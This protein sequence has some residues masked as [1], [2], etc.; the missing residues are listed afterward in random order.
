MFSKKKRWGWATLK[1]LILAQIL[2][3]CARFF[4]NAAIK[5]SRDA[6][7]KSPKMTKASLK[8]AKCK[9]KIF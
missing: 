7:L 4:M 5:Q 8:K 2:Y 9:S 3:R 6:N 1:A